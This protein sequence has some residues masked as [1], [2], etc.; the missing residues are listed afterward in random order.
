MKRALVLVLG[1]LLLPSAFA[2]TLFESNWSTATGTSIPAL[3]DSMS[4]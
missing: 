3:H 4:V 1:L 2:A